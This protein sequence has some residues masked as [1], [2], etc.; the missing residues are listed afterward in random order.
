MDQH[1]KNMLQTGVS[2]KILWEQPLKNYTTFRIGGPAS[3]VIKVSNKDELLHVLQLT[4]RYT[5]P[6]RVIGKGSNLLVDDSGFQG[7][8]LILTG[9]FTDISWKRSQS[10]ILDVGAGCS[11][12][13]V[14]SFCIQ[15]GLSGFEFCAGIPGTI[16]GAVTMNA[17]AWG[18]SIGEILESVEVL[19]VK[20][21]E[22]YDVKMLQFSYRKTSGLPDHA[23]ITAA[24]LRLATDSG[25][26]VK[27][28]CEDLLKKRKTTQPTC[29]P[30]AGSMFKNPEGESAGRLIDRCGLKGLRIGDAQISE[31]H[32]NFI[33]NRGCA[34]FR[35]V[36]ALITLI[37]E[38]V[39]VVTGIKLEPE[40]RFLC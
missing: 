16:G 24:R 2:E 23:I 14:T 26:F 10:Q 31:K 20:G 35:D 17:G 38:K 12:R 7:V 15:N 8:V 33:I 28:R 3:A 34:T 11:N 9:G 19:T 4:A 40:V 22:R 39:M 25:V 6:W 18:C 1:C 5:I 36:A 21:V 37:Q 13:V 27:Q 30:N 32:A 29:L